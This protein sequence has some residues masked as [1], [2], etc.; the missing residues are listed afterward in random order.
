MSAAGIVILA[1]MGIVCGLSW[2][3]LRC[4]QVCQEL[5]ERNDGNL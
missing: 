4:T 5:Q 3:L 2:S 1:L